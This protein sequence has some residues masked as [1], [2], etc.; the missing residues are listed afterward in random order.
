MIVDIGKSLSHQGVK[1]LAIINGHMGNLVAMKD[2]A[3]L[4]Y[5]ST[6]MKVLS[7]TYP[8]IS[9]IEKEVRESHKA[10]STYFHACEIETS[11]M[12]YLAPEHVIMDKAIR[13]I[14]GQFQEK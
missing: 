13:R 5:E 7:L 1:I 4:L 12:L 6:V 10:H 9:D 2:A 8:G 3:R 11:Y 14:A